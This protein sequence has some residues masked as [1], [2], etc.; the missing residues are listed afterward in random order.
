[1]ST[2]AKPGTLRSVDVEKLRHLPG[3]PRVGDIDA[4]AESL[5]RFGQY[6]PIVVRQETME[7]LA[8]NHTLDAARSLEWKKI[9]AFLIDVD[10]D[11]AKRIALADNKIAELGS[12]DEG[13]LGQMLATVGEDL[14]GLGWSE[15]EVAE[16]IEGAS[17]PDSE[18]SAP[19]EF[20]PV[21]PDDLL[22]ETTCPKCGY[23]F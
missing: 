4:I 5:K 22:T 1:M 7:V 11:D 13:A 9:K 12:Y 17:Q 20:D 16:L 21:K 6:R 14:S 10:E 15:D 23:E 8:G 18:G 2:K 3:N 19:G